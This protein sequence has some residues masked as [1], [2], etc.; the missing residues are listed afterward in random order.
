MEHTAGTPGLSPR[1]G[2]ASKNS[3]SE[4][5]VGRRGVP[6]G[7]DNSEAE[8]KRRNMALLNARKYFR[9]TGA[10]NDT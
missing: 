9:G 3:C 1:S 6:G 8:L 5:G 2:Q 10:Q 7:G 4:Q